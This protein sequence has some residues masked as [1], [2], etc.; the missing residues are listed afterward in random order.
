MLFHLIISLGC[1]PSWWSLLLDNIFSFQKF[2]TI[3]TQ[4]TRFI[5]I[6]QRV[7]YCG[8]QFLINS[9]AQRRMKNELAVLI[10]A[11][12]GTTLFVREGK[13]SQE[14]RKLPITSHPSGKTLWRAAFAIL[15][16]GSNFWRFWHRYALL[17]MWQT[18]LRSILPPENN[19]VGH[20]CYNLVQGSYSEWLSILARWYRVIADKM[21]R[22]ATRISST[23]KR[24]DAIDNVDLLEA[25]LS[26]PRRQLILPRAH[27]C[28]CTCQCTQHVNVH[29]I[30]EYIQLPLLKS[31]AR[32]S[33]LDVCSLK[34]VYTLNI[35]AL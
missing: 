3:S 12:H 22:K 11:Q 8:A 32:L 16:W 15:F 25:R 10:M 29:M 20:G 35:F 24:F 18:L 7:R 17:S 28:M 31:P 23:T 34:H 4:L 9:S 27:M 2:N 5:S 6:A 33:Q 13:T 30:G 1:D 26:R 21:S 14:S 19:M